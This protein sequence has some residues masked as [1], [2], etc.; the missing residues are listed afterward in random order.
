MLT[1][2][3]LYRLHGGGFI[4]GSNDTEELINRQLTLEAGLIIFSLD[5][6]L[7]PEHTV[8]PT[9]YNDAEDGLNWV[10]IQIVTVP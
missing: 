6:R 4:T 1:S 5:Y 9:I 3:S 2:N 7:A 10:C 8:I